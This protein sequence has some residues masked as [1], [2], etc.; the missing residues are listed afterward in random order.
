[1][2]RFRALLRSPRRARA[3]GARRFHFDADTDGALS[4][5]SRDEAGRARFTARVSRDWSIGGTPN[6]GFLS[7]LA[8]AAALREAPRE[9]P[10]FLSWSAFFVARAD[11]AAPAELVVERVGARARAG[12][13]HW[14][15]ELR[16]SGAA[17]AHF[18]GLL[19][20]LGRMRGPSLR[21]RGPMTS[22]PELP[23]PEACADAAAAL[24]ARV[25]TP[26]A[27][28]PRFD[29]ARRYELRVAA[30]SRFARAVLDREDAA[31]A[32][33]AAGDEPVSMEAWVGFDDGRPPLRGET[34]PVL[35]LDAFPPPILARHPTPWVPTLEYTVH[36]F[37]PPSEA[38]DA[39]FA[40][41]RFEASL[42]CSSLI[43]EDG[44]LWTADGELVARSRQLGRLL[45]PR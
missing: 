31:A 15:V 41:A 18:A 33:G 27:A 28:A 3:L 39:R 10:H 22:A 9:H 40:R 17:R 32:G 19:G 12:T 26:S 23:P 2:A 4:L 45:L 35:L 25:A 8:L 29:I 16:Q 5:A 13:S 21:A 36:R 7:A 20:D 38:D 11:E 37:R 42:M 6:G 30:D 1:M 43:Q 34:A 24:R 14:R 44:A